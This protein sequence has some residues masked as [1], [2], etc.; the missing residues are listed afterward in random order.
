[1][2]VDQPVGDLSGTDLETKSLQDFQQ[3]GFA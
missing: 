3:L 1:M 2:D